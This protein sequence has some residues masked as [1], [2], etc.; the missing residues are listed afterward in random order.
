MGLSTMLKFL[1]IGAQKAGTTW[2]YENLRKHPDIYFPAGKEIHFWDNDEAVKNPENYVSLFNQKE[3]FGGDITPAYSILE[4]ERISLI[5]ERFPNL[6]I[7]FMVRD[8]RERAWSSAKMAMARAELR[9]HEVSDQ[10]FIDHFLSRGSKLR[11]DY[12]R[13]I[14][15]WSYFFKRESICVVDFEKLKESPFEV[16]YA[17][18]SHISEDLVSNSE[19][20]KACQEN[21]TAQIFLGQAMDPSPTLQ[22]FLN[23][24]YRGKMDEF[25]NYVRTMGLKKV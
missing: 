13:T 8:P 7:I 24:L 2:L 6:K 21:C 5:Y 25:N 23:D 22:S 9:G 11:G 18:L 10:W 15:N 12:I 1:G 16:I 3:M 19:S 4:K 20:L 17:V 14:K